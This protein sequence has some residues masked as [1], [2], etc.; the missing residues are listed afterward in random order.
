[1]P[2]PAYIAPWQ[3]I[4]PKLCPRPQVIR[5]RPDQ[6]QG[7]YQV[8]VQQYGGLIHGRGKK[9]GSHPKEDLGKFQGLDGTIRTVNKETG[10]RVTMSHKCSELDKHIP[11]FLRVSKPI[12]EHVVFCHHEDSPWS[13]QEGAVLKKRFD[14]IFDSTRYAKALGAIKAERKSYGKKHPNEYSNHI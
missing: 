7:Q 4:G 13:L 12:L 6:L 10:E 9:H 5:P 8:E 3:Q 14:D 1:M 11:F 2:S